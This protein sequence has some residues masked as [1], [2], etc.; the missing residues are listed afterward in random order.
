MLRAIL[1]FA[2][3]IRSLTFPPAPVLTEDEKMVLGLL[4]P[5]SLMAESEGTLLAAI[6]R[7][8]GQPRQGLGWVLG[9]LQ[10]LSAL[11]LVEQRSGFKTMTVWYRT[12]LGSKQVHA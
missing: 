8:T 6:S 7:R 12:P 2:R 3:D 4:S 9:I 1:N 5:D 11:G 10:K